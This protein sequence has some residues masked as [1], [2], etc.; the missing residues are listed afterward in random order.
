MKNF[1]QLFFVFYQPI[2]SDRVNHIFIPN[3]LFIIYN[4]CLPLLPDIKNISMKKILPIVFMA[5]AATGVSAQSIKPQTATFEDY[6]PLLNHAG[7]Q[8]YS[9]DISEFLNDTYLVTFKIK[10]YKDG[11]EVENNRMDYGFTNRRMIKDFPEESQ[12]EILQ[13]GSAVNPEAGVY[14]QS[15]KLSFGFSPGKA[16]SLKTLHLS[17]EGIGAGSMPLKLQGLQSSGEDKLF[18]AYQDRPFKVD[19]F[20]EGTFIPL[21]LYGSFWY[22]EKNKVFRFCGEKEIDPDMST[23]ILKYIPHYYVIG[24]EFVKQ[25]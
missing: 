9:F 25:K 23:D 3:L 5:L 13:E 21:V 8:V 4:K 16:D 11:M 2:L 6:I 17:L 12:K 14:S 10:E 7:Y 20:E 22:D 24:V 15:S 1:Y 19:K 18:Y